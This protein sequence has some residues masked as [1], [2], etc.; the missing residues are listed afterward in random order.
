MKALAIV[1]LVLAG[2]SFIIPFGAY[3]TVVSGLM[4]AVAV[5]QGIT[6]LSGVTVGLNILNILFFSPML[7]M[8][9]TAADMSARVG[10]KHDETSFT[11]IPVVLLL[12]QVIF[13]AVV[14]YR[15]RKQKS[16]ANK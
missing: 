8:A 13:L 2:L 3:F 6:V 12:L 4:A 5:G 9:T 14:I 10:N 1:A 16:L 15:D 7:W 11:A